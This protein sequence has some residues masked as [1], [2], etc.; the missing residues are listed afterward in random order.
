MAVLYE[1]EHYPAVLYIELFQKCPQYEEILFHELVY[2]Y[3]TFSTM[4]A[5]QETLFFS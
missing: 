4:V 3:Y 1:L 5:S 2:H